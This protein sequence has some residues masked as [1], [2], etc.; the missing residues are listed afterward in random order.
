MDIS[1]MNLLN[2]PEFQQLITLFIAPLA[3]NSISDRLKA[4]KAAIKDK[5]HE[6]QLLDCLEKAFFETERACHWKHDTE[7]IYETF[8]GSLMSFSGSF[9]QD[10]LAKIF[11]DAV[12]TDVTDRQI[13][14]WVDNVKKQ[15]SLEEHTKLREYLLV[16]YIMQDQTPQSESKTKYSLTSSTSIYDNP[17]IICRDEFIDDL[18]QLLSSGHKRIQITGMG[19]LGKTEVLKKVYAKLANAKEKSK[20]DHIAYIQFNGEIS[21]DIEAQIGYPNP[22]KK[23]QGINASNL[24]LHDL[25]SDKNVLLCIDDI[26]TNPEL[27]KAEHSCIRYLNSLGATVLLASRVIYPSFEVKPLELLPT[28]AC[29]EIFRKTYGQSI[30]NQNDLEVLKSIIEDRAGNHTLVVSRLGSM[31]YDCG[32]SVPSL[33]KELNE[34]NFNIATD[35]TDETAFQNEINKLYLVDEKLT[36]SEKIILAAFSI[37]PTIPLPYELCV[38]WLHEDAKVDSNR[39]ALTLTKLSKKTWLTRQYGLNEES[40]S[41]YMHPIVK[42]A[43]Q[44]QLCVEK[45][46]LPHMIEHITSAV[47]KLVDS[48]DLARASELI[49]FA[50]STILA[51][52]FDVEAYFALSCVIADYYYKTANYKAAEAWQRFTL[53]NL[54]KETGLEHP[55]VAMTENNLASALHVQGNLRLSLDLYIK[56]LDVFEKQPEKDTKTISTIRS[57]IAT[58]YSELDELDLSLKWYLKSLS[59]M[60]QVSAAD[61]QDVAEI[62]SNIAGIYRRKGD[63]DLSR[64]YFEKADLIY[65]ELNLADRPTA[66]NHYNNF[67]FLYI[68]EGKDDEALGLFLKALGIREK[69]LGVNHPETASTY[70]NISALYEKKGEFDIALSYVIKAQKVCEKVYGRMNVRTAITYNNIGRIHRKLREYQLALDWHQNAIEIYEKVAAYDKTNLGVLYSNLADVYFDQK[71][72]ELA[73]GW[74]EKARTTLKNSA[75]PNDQIIKYVENRMTE[76]EMNIVDM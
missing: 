46:T 66:A 64:E 36:E 9:N 10:S 45:P 40:P 13:A 59:L 23:L 44:S 30:S 74:Y 55:F 53:D 18:L 76:V 24:F 49:P 3:V 39:C 27:L 19:G 22:Y 63:R 70:N 17:E 25:C 51:V 60:N 7:A 1:I 37:F 8:M 69:I 47:F 2:S 32:W 54:I 31:A 57:N 56:S 71:H 73:Q 50:S 67:A 15:I 33:L 75:Y 29:V 34:Q 21:D 41:C 20:F 38:D 62:Y 6:E 58:L 42:A 68:A 16:G 65:K 4:L 52:A 5:T 72:Y 14:L 26:R 61:K 48:Y 12:G 43:V 28:D 35:V 11:R